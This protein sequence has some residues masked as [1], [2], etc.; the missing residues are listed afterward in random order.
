MWLTPYVARPQDGCVSE[1]TTNAPS[2]GLPPAPQ[3]GPPA[4]PTPQVGTTTSNG[5]A[6]AA[7]VLGIVGL[8]TS[9]IPFLFVIGPICDVLAIIFGTI[10]LRRAKRGADN[11]SMAVAGLILG[12]CGVVIVILWVLLIVVAIHSDS[13]VGPHFH[14]FL[15]HA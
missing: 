3:A 10:G 5:M 4:P 15:L 11:K 13:N 8:V 1:G 2:P 7:L 6:V 12:I 14:T 9:I